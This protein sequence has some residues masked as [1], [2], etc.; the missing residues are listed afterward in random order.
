MKYVRRKFKPHDDRMIAHMPHTL[1]IFG[2]ERKNITYLLSI[3]SEVEE[4]CKENIGEYLKEWSFGTSYKDKIVFF[5]TSKD[6][7]FAF[8]LRWS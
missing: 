3:G 4:W 7:A 6:K 8:K 1:Q 2:E 5:F